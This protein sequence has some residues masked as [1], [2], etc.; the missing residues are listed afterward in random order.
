MAATATTYLDWA[1]T[2][3]PQPP[4]AADYR[5]GNPS[6]AHACGRGQRQA[7]AAARAQLAALI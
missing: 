1:A 2:A 5:L 7:L 3:P 6:S 4:A